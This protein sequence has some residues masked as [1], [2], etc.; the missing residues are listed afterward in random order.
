MTTTVSIGKLS[1][2]ERL[3][4]VT[5][6]RAMTK[7]TDGY[8]FATVMTAMG[9]MLVNIIHNSMPDLPVE[10]RLELVDHHCK[11][12]RLVVEEV[13]AGRAEAYAT[14]DKANVIGSGRG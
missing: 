6:L 1:P 4:V 2:E 14:D 3:Q 13:T 12:I 8:R 11:Y 7:A 10:K 9:C 5:I